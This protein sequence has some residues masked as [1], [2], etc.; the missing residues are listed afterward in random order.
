LDAVVI[1]VFARRGERRPDELRSL[2]VDALPLIVIIS[3]VVVIGLIWLA[4]RR[5][6][7]RDRATIKADMSEPDEIEIYNETWRDRE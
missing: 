5:T 3:A 2:P 1:V 6:I 4:L 7:Q